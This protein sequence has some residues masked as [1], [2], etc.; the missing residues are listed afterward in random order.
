MPGSPLNDIISI[1]IDY[2]HV[3]QMEVT[4]REFLMIRD[5]V[6][7]VGIVYVGALL[8]E[9]ARVEI[10]I[11]VVLFV[12]NLLDTSLAKGII[13]TG[14][15]VAGFVDA[16]AIG[17][18]ELVVVAHFAPV[19]CITLLARAFLLHRVILAK[20]VTHHVIGF[21]IG[22]DTCRVLFSTG[23]VDVQLLLYRS[24]SSHTLFTSLARVRWRADAASIVSYLSLGHWVALLR[25][26][27]EGRV[28]RDV[29][30]EAIVVM[31]VSH[32]EVW[33]TR[34]RCFLLATE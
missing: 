16:C 13:S 19:A 18:L 23:D 9:G 28:F 29:L 17:V 22:G 27:Q 11:R 4:T 1:M 8:L 32:S 2:M 3:S 34:I 33:L 26:G 20:V 25:P 5:L 24:E 6:Q 31:L 7:K 30:T 14:L 10:S 21:H 12:V 15:H